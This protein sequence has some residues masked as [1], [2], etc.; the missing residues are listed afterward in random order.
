RGSIDVGA[1]TVS[2]LGNLGSSFSQTTTAAAPVPAR[3]VLLLHGAKYS[4]QT[5]GDLGTLALLANA[6]YR[7]AAV[8]LPVLLSNPSRD[9]L[10]E[11]ICLGLGMAE[12]APT[13]IVSPSMSGSFSVPLLLRRPV[14]S[15]KKSGAFRRLRA[16]GAGPGSFLSSRSLRRCDGSP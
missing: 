15:P 16:G 12:Q 14:G 8:D 10:L 6:G 3:N 4:A 9:E 13:V 11:R 5:W 2:F 1:T 7:V